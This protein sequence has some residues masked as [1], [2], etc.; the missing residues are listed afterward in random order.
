MSKFANIK[1]RKAPPKPAQPPDDPEQSKRFIEAA[2]EIG[3]DESPETF[4]NVFRRITSSRT[5]G[6]AKDRLERL[7]EEGHKA[8]MPRSPRSSPPRPSRRAKRTK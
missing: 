8:K 6:A 3:T 4:E 5:K 7:P 2:R 1:E